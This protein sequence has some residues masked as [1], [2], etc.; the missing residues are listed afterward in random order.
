MLKSQSTWF[1]LNLYTCR[2]T[3]DCLLVLVS[4]NA[5]T[6]HLFIKTK[7]LKQS[8]NSF[9]ILSQYI[10]Q[11]LNNK[12]WTGIFVTLLP[13]IL[14]QRNLVYICVRQTNYRVRISSW[15]FELGFP[16]GFSNKDVESVFSRC[17]LVIQLQ[18]IG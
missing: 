16:V 4:W 13:D 5:I 8:K 14:S 12:I 9:E 17:L 18:R 15:I 10:M 7:S 3:K 2:F 6:K 1:C 11:K